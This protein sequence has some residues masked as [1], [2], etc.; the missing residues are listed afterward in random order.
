MHVRCDS[1]YK[2]EADGGAI[3]GQPVLFECMGIWV[4][5]QAH[6]SEMR[7]YLVYLLIVTYLSR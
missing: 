4:L 3:L 1:Q 5:S 2:T 6:E 7:D